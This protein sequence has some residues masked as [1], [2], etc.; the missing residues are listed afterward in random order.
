MTNRSSAL[1]GLDRVLALPAGVALLSG[2]AIAHIPSGRVDRVM[3]ALTRLWKDLG[4]RESA[5]TLLTDYLYGNANDDAAEKL[6]SA[7]ES[8][9]QKAKAKKLDVLL[10]SV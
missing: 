8:A 1:A 3:L 7:L 9:L 6:I 4:G 2:H 5:A 10:L